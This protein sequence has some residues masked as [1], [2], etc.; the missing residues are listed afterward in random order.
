MAVDK[1]DLLAD[2]VVGD[3]DRLLGIALVV[4][5]DDLDLAPGDAARLIDQCGG[6]IGPGLELIADRSE[7]AGH[8]AGDRYRQIISFHGRRQNRQRRTRN[9][10]DERL[11]HG[12]VL[13]KQGA[14]SAN[15]KLGDDR[16]CAR[17]SLHCAGA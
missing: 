15:A 10:Q 5:D 8:R 6:R 13:L 3:R 12:I 11:S 9:E 16:K 7:L 14:Y 4:L 2:D 17:A 1:L